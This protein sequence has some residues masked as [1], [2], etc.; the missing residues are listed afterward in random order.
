MVRSQVLTV[1]KF[2][3][4]WNSK[5]NLVIHTDPLKTKIHKVE[6]AYM[7]TVKLSMGLRSLQYMCVY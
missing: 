5:M 2:I 1:R 3:R 6:N 4:L 7:F